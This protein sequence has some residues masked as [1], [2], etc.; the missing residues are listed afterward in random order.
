M[1]FVTSISPSHVNNDQQLKAVE[2]W[3]QFGDVY[4][5]NHKSE[6]QQLKEK[7]PKVEFV[8][9]TRTLEHVYNKPYVMISAV[10]DW[11]K[12]KTYEQ[13]CIIN[14]DIEIK[15]TKETIEKIKAEMYNSLVLSN[16]VNHNGDYRG[17]QY[18]LGIDAFFIHKR[19][20]SIYNQSM[21]CFGQ[22]FWDYWIPYTA[23]KKGIEVKFIKKD[24]AF[25]LD[26]P[27]QY[28]EDMW[29]KSGRYF[30]WENN[31]Y[32]FNDRTEIGTMS[33]FVFNFIY[34]ASQRVEI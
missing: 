9:T 26:H 30:L 5:F 3:L 29:K 27:A 12:S 11:C 10:L 28:N 1:I 14:S 18:L 24:I 7:V 13:Y 22:C 8:E 16:R 6:I 21:H 33:R 25:H 17:T 20:M 32:Q 15:T 4:S 19:F 2:S 23:I 34:N 31:L